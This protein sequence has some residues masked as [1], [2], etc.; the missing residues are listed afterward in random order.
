MCMDVLRDED[1]KAAKDHP[2][3]WCTE[4]ILKGEKYHLQA[5]VYDAE[6]CTNR[7]HPECFEVASESFLEGDCDFVPNQCKRGS[8]EAA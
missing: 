2:C 6:M 1:P 8:R 7:Y 3:I 4:K 5:G